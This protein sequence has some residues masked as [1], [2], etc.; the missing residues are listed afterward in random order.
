MKK[1]EKKILLFMPLIGSG[2]VEKN[3]FIIANFLATK[4]KKIY[5][6]NSY[7]K[8]KS[9]LKENII[10]IDKYKNAE[11]NLFLIYFKTIIKLIKFLILNRNVTVLSFQA[12]LYCIIV[13]KL[14]GARIIARSN[15]SPSGWA[16]NILKRLIFKLIMQLADNLIVNS[17]EF[18]KEMKNKLNLNT[19]LILNPLNQKTIKVLSKKKSNFNFF[20]N[21]KFLKIVSIGRLVFQKDHLTLLKALNKIKNKINFKLV[22]IGE[23]PEKNS[24]LNFINENNL[25]KKIKVIKFQKNPYSLINKSDLF[26]LTSRYEGLPNVL[27]EAAVLKKFII[28]TKCPTGPLEI[29]SNGRYGLL[30]NVGDYESLAKQIIKF[31]NI[32]KMKKKE[33]SEKLYNS[34]YKY[35]SKNNLEKYLNILS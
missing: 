18:K 29:L 26:I 17:Y 3:F 30:F 7:I 16:N 35:D 28:S 14:F 25:S 1:D 23:G 21:F 10:F 6:C 31:C 22:I 15:A 11:N 32:P 12:N 34:L 2:G 8:N 33:V 27:L 13:A 19:N 20:K 5:I 9:N 4:F 24:L